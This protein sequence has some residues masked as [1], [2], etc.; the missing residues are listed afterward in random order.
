MNAV[1]SR[2]QPARRA[3]GL[4]AAAALV[5]AGF[6]S[7]PALPAAADV[8]PLPAEADVFLVSRTD[9]GSSG[10]PYVTPDGQKVAYVS[11]AGDLVE[12]TQIET[13]N[14]F[15]ATATPGSGDP[16]SGTPELVSRPDAALP[17]EP[18]NDLSYDPVASADGRHIAF[19]SHA[20]N[21][22][23]GGSTPGRANV[24]VHDMLTGAT[25]RL[26]AGAEPNGN[27]FD[28][29]I[30]D[31][32]Q[33]VVF[34][35]DATNLSADD[36]NGA[37]DVFIADL[38]ADD[39][40]TRGDVAIT[41]L[42]AL[43]SVPGGTSQPAIS[44]DGEWIVYTTHIDDPTAPGTA[45][46]TPYVFRTHRGVESET[47]MVFE[48]AH[49]GAVDAIGNAFAAIVDNCEGEPVIAGATLDS[50]GAP[51]AVGVGWALV[52]RR[53]G[54]L[55][56]PV[57]SSDG[58]TI[59]W[60][61]TQPEFD[62]DLGGVVPDPLPEPVVRVGHPSWWDAS[63]LEVQ[64]DGIRDDVTEIGVG[65]AVGLSASGRTV[66]FGGPS[67]M[68]AAEQSVTAV[69]RHTH[70]GLSVSNTM[71]ELSIPGYVTSVPISDIPVSAVTDYG[72][73]LANAPIYRLP[74]YRLPIYRLPIYRLP[75]YR[76]LIGD[77]PIYRLG[78]DDAP[79]YRLPIYRLPI[80]RLPIYRLDI[81]GGWTELLAETEFAGDLEQS[82]TLADVLAWAEATLAG[83]GA[84]PAERDAAE[85][86]QSL[87]LS[88][89]GLEGTG[90]DA[91]SIASLIL[92]GAPLAEVAIAGE[93]SPLERWQALVDA[94][95]LGIGVD[96][97][98]VLAELDAAGL[99]V[100][101]TGV[102]AVPLNELPIAET[103]FDEL[104]MAPADGRPGLF[105]EG[106]P[107][108]A[109]DVD[110][111][112]PTAQ[113][114]LFGGS[115]DGT[116]AENADALLPSATVAD[117]ARGAPDA[118][119]F[120]MLLFSVL[121]STTYPWEQIDPAV[122]PADAD[123]EA[124]LGW[125]CNGNDRCGT[126][127]QF[128]FTFDPGPGEPTAFAAPTA[129][130]VLPASSRLD[131]VRAGGSGPDL[132]HDAD[133][134]YDG[135][136][137]TDGSLVRFPLPDSTA[138]TV[139]MLGLQYTDSRQPGA[140]SA[141][142]ELTSGELR[143]EDEIFGDAPQVYYDVPAHNRTPG[144]EWQ[145][146]PKTLT[147]GTVN[148]EWI[149]PAWMDL[150]DYGQ[151]IQ[152]PAEDEDWYYV[153][154]PQPGERLVIAS[155]A[156]DGQIA[157]SLL[158]PERAQAPLGVAADGDA[159][160][161]AVT[162][163][164]ARDAASPAESGA[165]AGSS[166]PG[167]VLVDQAVVGGDG[168]ATVQA[169][170]AAADGDGKWLV[171]V[172]SGNGLASRQ[173][174]SLRATYVPE[175][176]EQRC[177]PWSP[178]AG[179]E[180]EDP[181][182]PWPVIESDPVTSATNTVYLMDTA[183]FRAMHG[184][185]ATEDVVASIR[186]LDGVGTVGD[187]SVAG[188]ILS[189][190][191]D[192]AVLAARFALDAQP[193]SMTARR[194]LSAAINAYVTSAIGAQSDHISSVVIIGGDDMI[195][196]APVAQNTGQ[197]NEASHAAQLKLT[198]QPD[199]SACPTG[200]G[201]D[202]VD[203]CA[204]PLSAAAAANYILTD[205]PYGLAVA[206]Q[207]LGGYLYVPTAAVGRLVDSPDQIRG[208]LARFRYADGMLEADSALSGGYGAWA[209]LP[210]LV[211]EN[212]AWRLGDGD[213]PLAEPWTKDEAES[214][215]FPPD[216]DEAP[217]V[218]SLNTHADERRLL[219]G[220]EG[221][222]GGAVDEADLIEADDHAPPL[223]P[224]ADEV[225]DPSAST[226]PL[227]GSL[228]FL[229]GCHAGNNLPDSYYG[230]VTDWADVF[231]AAG[232]YV[233][234]TG[235]GLANNV[236]TA[237]SERLL[238]LYADWI[239]VQTEAGAVSSGGAL[240]FA[241]Q[242]YLGGLGLYTGYDEKV[243][244]Q[245]VYYG[246]PMYSFTD[247]TKQQPLPP[248]PDLSVVDAG[249]GL[250]SAALTLTP[251]FA[252]VTR[253]D[254]T[255][256][257][258]TFVS[259]D[260]EQ[261]LAA[262]GQPLLPR[263]VTRIPSTDD[264]GNIPRGALITSLESEWSGTVRPAIGDPG[265]GVEQSGVTKDGLAFPSQFTSIS[266]QSTPDGPVA[267]VV[268][269]PASVQSAHGGL[270]RIETFPTMGLEVLYGPEGDSVAPVIRSTEQRAGFSM[271]AYDST[272]DGS[273]GVITRAVLL[274]QSAA[275][276]DDGA[277]RV[278]ETVELAPDPYGAWR[279]DI[280]DS[281]DGPYRWILQVVDGAG[282]VT[283]DSAR[284]RIQVTDA[285]PP[286]L[287]D[288]GADA[289]V[290]AGERVVRSIPVTAA[291]GARVTG[292]YRLLDAG[293]N[294]RGTGALTVSPAADGSL[295]A[296]FD[297]TFPTPGTF[298]VVLT[299]CSGG[300]TC[301]EAVSFTLTATAPNA[302]PTATVSL[303]D[304]EVTPVSTL[305]AE[306]SGADP[307]DDDV[308][309]AYRWLRNGVPIEDADGPTLDL[310]GLAQE[311]DVIRV[312]VTP[313]DGTTAG[314]AASAEV[315][316]AAERPLPTIAVWATSAG[317]TYAEG[318]WATADVAVSFTCTGTGVDCPE[319]ETVSS[320]TAGRLIERTVADEYGRTAS[321][322][323]TVMLD[324]TA[325]ALA[326]AV[327]PDPVAVGGAA[328]ATAGATDALSGLAGE[329]CDAPATATA[330]AKTLICRATDVAGNTASATVAYTVLAPTT[331]CQ[332]GSRIVMQPLNADG[333]SVFPRV[334]GVPIA[335]RLCDE[336]GQPVT[337][338]GSVTSVT[339]VSS[340]ALPKKGPAVNELPYLIPAV[341]PVYV[342][343]TGLWAGSLGSGTLKAG[344]KYTYRVN[345]ADGSSFTFSFGVK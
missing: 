210:Q 47:R 193:C 77:S 12:G 248:A 186:A 49:H 198:E 63:S 95:G 37:A 213:T 183:R 260:S 150:D 258:V 329:S 27:A 307:D 321:A 82:V 7:L 157:L 331:A 117:L 335:F 2:L 229:I 139:R 78:V 211:S 98:M 286:V 163:Q 239:G 201:A 161:T 302:A 343:L 146:T 120:G 256:A 21:L 94:Q 38:D 325:P 257:E 45:G 16:F 292:S 324:K 36:A 136:V 255:G 295:R 315:V 106:T 306:A 125:S 334:S 202:D 5:A 29:D 332:A 111:L 89:V 173:L 228:V 311:D 227:D 182:E 336:F 216:A 299:A 180:V 177:T 212:L 170:S 168:T 93:G 8:Q 68:T 116:L 313:H 310:A 185:E 272:D 178:P 284:G 254:Q 69:D 187:G 320:D 169:S 110:D 25:Y 231:G 62:F 114:A 115:R 226:S 251:S 162:E 56:E 179:V 242:A 274:V 330:G 81:P 209:E 266:H 53:V 289:T 127:A 35:S 280:P 102:E 338:E 166:A 337:A 164:E 60:S 308:E 283:T 219:A 140:W 23:P 26:D 10:S 80:Y 130:V 155:N 297:A 317:D 181:L 293:E 104:P 90:I 122:I 159:P 314:H 261:P 176:P 203:P 235:F 249:D 184:L 191:T 190:D 234:N 118:V 64:C 124:T 171:R 109:I 200:L 138:G 243:L 88:D 22:V 67:D 46:D 96:D 301:G 107:L 312:E 86:I 263:V 222:E 132:A 322:S 134:L 113:A 156:S 217:R 31:D 232:G 303:G 100:D 54:E 6:V 152:G 199:G 153:E 281:I 1:P 11:T 85:R 17:D 333:S 129:S 270:G 154:P 137:Q 71:G 205:D 66:V 108:G 30:S 13:P 149:S 175:A 345:L 92:G 245:S 126:V 197:F 70:D 252:T 76:L 296:V 225:F 208:Q 271:S 344:L 304:A 135:P 194:D 259:A 121:D 24:Y 318:T 59:A 230:D 340:A 275:P 19:V 305:I 74:I 288:P 72:A 55:W 65:G 133:G 131:L 18:A 273:A 287:G 43:H 160:G 15:L 265:I 128:R 75:I 327:T 34:T 236:T 119:T 291:S 174:Y 294:E 247:S 224:P 73:A 188:A 207:S 145:G 9:Q 79:I 50:S 83:P 14:V 246:V 42:L 52:D 319:P 148:Y 103:M 39:D 269:T 237:L 33:Y 123:T 99:D 206:Y 253:T 290:T 196:F 189:V 91:L 276:A 3:V 44:G 215:L 300:L 282:N 214:L 84:S 195:P 57:I 144:G 28:P 112:S 264:A 223:V 204:T 40:G 141:R 326:P 172:T 218:V 339:P 147:A 51:F 101:Q 142:A 220:V 167:Q 192:P 41:R 48:G 298:T 285:A 250:A 342:P 341:K 316:V 58:S 4:T 241:K 262:A 143:A 61:T 323:I 165:D 279:G 278:W 87:S 267:L 268:T 244:M 158:K 233:G 221:A 20:T 309:L 151:P 277:A 32:G 238:G 328:T 97:A 240:T 105:L